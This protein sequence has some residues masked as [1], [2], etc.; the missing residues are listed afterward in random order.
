MDNEESVIN[1]PTL[2]LK[3]KFMTTKS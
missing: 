3:E 1:H 2:Y